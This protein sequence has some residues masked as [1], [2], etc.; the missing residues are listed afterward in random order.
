LAAAN[1]A[2]ATKLFSIERM[3]SGIDRALAQ[4]A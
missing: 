2:R 3:L 1:F 4:A